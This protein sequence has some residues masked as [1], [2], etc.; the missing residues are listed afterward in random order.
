MHIKEESLAATYSF[1]LLR[2]PAL[3][4]A[5]LSWRNFRSSTSSSSSLLLVSSPSFTEEGARTTCLRSLDRLFLLGI[6]LHLTTRPPDDHFLLYA[7]CGENVWHCDMT[8]ETLGQQIPCNFTTKITS[9]HHHSAL[10]YS[11]IAYCMI[12]SNLEWLWFFKL[13][14]PELYSSYNEKFAVDCT[15]C[16]GQNSKPC[17]AVF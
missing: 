6:F 5:R 9:L 13:T 2:K 14:Q 17:F 16:A 12:V 15:L 1:I 7:Q 8:V 11:E 3:P 4:S 10:V